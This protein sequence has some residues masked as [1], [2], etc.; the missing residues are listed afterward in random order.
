MHSCNHLFFKGRNEQINNKNT[1]QIFF[2]CIPQSLEF[3]IQNLSGKNTT[4]K[5][6]KRNLNFDWFKR[7]F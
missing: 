1:A 4:L 6:G 2:R 7:V 3:R 5:S